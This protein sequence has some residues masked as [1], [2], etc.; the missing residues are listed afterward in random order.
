MAYVATD[1][2]GREYIYDD[3]PKKGVR[4]DGVK[5]WI[6][7]IGDYIELPKGSIKNLIGRSL[8]FSDEPVRLKEVRP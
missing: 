5:I 3:K 2:D 6:N 7:K 8:T 1:A 4:Y